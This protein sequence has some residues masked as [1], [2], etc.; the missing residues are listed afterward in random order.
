MS[1]LLE[2]KQ[3]TMQFGGLVAVNHV[4]MQIEQGNIHLLIGPNG[5]G[6]STLFNAITGLYIP[7]SGSVWFQGEEISK[8]KPHTITKLGIA[9]TFQNILLFDD[10]PVVENVMVG[11]HC[12]IGSSIL[13]D[14]LRTPKM[15]REEAHCRERAEELL[16]FV[17]LKDSIHTSAGSLPYGRK[18]ILEIARALASEPKM[19]MLDEPAAGM[20]PKETEEL[21][22]LIYKIRDSGVTLVVVEH[23]MR[24]AI[25]IADVV[26][27]IDH[28]MKIAEG[29]PRSVVQEPQVIEA[30]LGKE[31]EFA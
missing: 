28:G 21:I 14:I 7:T 4:D 31:V 17:G 30:Y 25:G 23:N 9:R 1:V 26:T 27:V 11:R 12:R 19:L 24:L 18:R 29:L 8:Y 15:R 13:T 5:A 6:K 3:L 16:E 10:L 2:A 22:E 20:N